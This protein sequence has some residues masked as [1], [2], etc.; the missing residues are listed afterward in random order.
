[1]SLVLVLAATAA[2][3]EDG[4]SVDLFFFPSPFLYTLGREFSMAL[5]IYT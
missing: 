3:M 1:L 2:A 4:L 5:F